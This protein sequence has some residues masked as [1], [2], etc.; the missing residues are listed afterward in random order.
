MSDVISTRIPAAVEH[1]LAE[2]CAKQGVSR[3]DVV[4]SALDEFFARHDR[5]PDAYRLAADLIPSR[6][7]ASL[8]SAD[9]R[10]LARTAF[11]AKRSR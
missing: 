9:V 3:T 4:L 1:R 6:G 7:V 5:K 11:G 2:Y 10:K 8:Q